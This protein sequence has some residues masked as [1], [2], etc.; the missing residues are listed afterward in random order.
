LNRPPTGIL[1]NHSIAG[2]TAAG[3][4]GY[5]G[6]RS[7]NAD[8]L[9]AKSLSIG[10]GTDPFLLSLCFPVDDRADGALGFGDVQGGGDLK[11]VNKEVPT[12]K[13]KRAPE[14]M[15]EAQ[16]Y[17]KRRLS[18]M[19]FFSSSFFD[20]GLEQ[21]AAVTAVTSKEID[22]CGDDDTASILSENKDE[23]I[24]DHNIDDDDDASIASV[25]VE[26]IELDMAD[27]NPAKFKTVVLAFTTSMENSAK[28]QQDIHDWDRKM[29]LKRSHS[30]TM[31]QSSRSRKKLRAILKK[32][33]S[34]MS[35]MA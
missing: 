24:G 21:L 10:F 3:G 34:A 13:A 26:P 23:A 33:M 20:D 7:N 29:G 16:F 15:E 27:V 4:Y 22:C 30:K 2:N 14:G 31:R 18:S 11:L 9:F 25:P 12:F 35:K 32:E 28:S 5:G 1:S 19:G 8:A 17:K 6:G